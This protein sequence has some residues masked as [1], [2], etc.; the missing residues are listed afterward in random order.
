[1]IQ[2]APM[3]RCNVGVKGVR[4]AAMTPPSSK[5]C[6]SLVCSLGLFLISARYSGHVTMWSSG[7]IRWDSWMTRCRT[8]IPAV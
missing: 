4:T 1:M 2:P 8:E 5:L 3:I 6:S 7:S